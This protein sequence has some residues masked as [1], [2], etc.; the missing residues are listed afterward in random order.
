LGDVLTFV[1]ITKQLSVF[2]LYFGRLELISYNG[3]DLVR[4]RTPFQALFVITD[5]VNK[6]YGIDKHGHRLLNKKE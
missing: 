4:F 6:Y 5:N 2:D 3:G 1:W